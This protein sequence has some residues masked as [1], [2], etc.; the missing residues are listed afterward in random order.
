MPEELRSSV[1]DGSARGGTARNVAWSY[2]GYAFQI[3]VNLGTTA[4]IVR[5]VSVPEYGL[6]LFVLSLSAGLYLLNAGLSS[7]LVQCY[8]SVLAEHDGERLNEL[9]STVFWALALLGFVG[10]LIFSVLAAILPGPFKIPGL[11][12]HKAA[13]I[14]VVAALVIQV[15][16]PRIAFDQAYQAGNRYDRINQIQLLTSALQ[17][18]LTVTILAAGGRIVAL[19]IVQLVVAVFNLLLLI[20]ALPAS[21]PGAS[22]RLTRFNGALLKPVVHLSKWAFLENLSV[23]LFNLCTWTVLGSLGSMGDAAIFGL[24]AKLPTQLRNAVEK[25]AHVVLPL[26]SECVVSNDPGGL[27]EIFFRTQRL[28]FGAVLPA[29]FLGCAFARPLI[30]LWA[31]DEY[32]HADIVM[33]LLLLAAFGDSILFSSYTLLYAAFRV[34]RAAFILCV[35]NAAGI[36]GI[37]LAISRYGAAGVAFAIA[38]AQVLMGAWFTL[39]ACKACHASPLALVR[40][41]LREVILPAIPMVLAVA[42][43]LC[44][45]NALSP[46]WQVLAAVVIG[47]AYLWLW[48][49]RTALPLLR[50]PTEAAL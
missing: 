19:A 24:A 18:A 16:L 11:F 8:V 4:Y 43:V 37:L 38:V 1:N 31:G 34:R 14:F 6:L 32:A 41:A 46:L 28:V 5:R 26:M 20:L 30:V 12:V 27:R 21:V 17:L 45:R 49:V 2:A 48:G 9:I 23:C 22:S 29:V 33:R 35:G 7:V 3:G 36:G 39:E 50:K 40:G 25:G 47:C 44:F 42:L 10:V 13:I 15:G